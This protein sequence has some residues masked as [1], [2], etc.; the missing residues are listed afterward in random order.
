MAEIVFSGAEADELLEFVE[1]EGSCILVYDAGSRLYDRLCE[2]APGEPCRWQL[3]ES[4]AAEMRAELDDCAD[5]AW[6]A[7]ATQLAARLR[8]IAAPGERPS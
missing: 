7:V 3:D 5:T 4:E 1:G 6:A 2:R 8:A